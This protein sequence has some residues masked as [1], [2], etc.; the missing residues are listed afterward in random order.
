M[1]F[2]TSLLTNQMEQASHPA[3]P[4]RP[5]WT[6]AS[7]PP[8]PWPQHRQHWDPT[9][10]APPNVFLASSS[11]VVMCMHQLVIEQQGGTREVVSDIVDQIVV[12]SS[13]SLSTGHIPDFLGSVPKEPNTSIMRNMTML[14]KYRSGWESLVKARKSWY[15][16]LGSMLF[17]ESRVTYKLTEPDMP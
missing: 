4:P 15:T 5:T 2:I 17:E 6:H 3:P 8:P 7:S 12:D 13:R 14:S 9:A 11:K 10:V 1:I 16:D